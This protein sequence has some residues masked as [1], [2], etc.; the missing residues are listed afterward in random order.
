MVTECNQGSQRVNGS[1][2]SNGALHFNAEDT[3]AFFAKTLSQ[4][5]MNWRIFR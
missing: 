4:S 2:F 5:Q 1:G 3:L